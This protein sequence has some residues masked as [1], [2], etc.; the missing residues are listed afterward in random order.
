M[1]RTECVDHLGNKFNSQTE[2]CKYWNVSVTTFIERQKRGCSMQECLVSK[3][4]LS[5][6][7]K[8]DQIYNGQITILGNYINSHSKILVH[9]NVC[10]NEWE[11]LPTVLIRKKHSSCPKCGRLNKHKKCT[12]SHD[13]WI[14]SI[15][16]DKVLILGK[17]TGL[18]NKILVRCTNNNCNHEWYAR[19]YDI[20]TG[21]GC[22][23]CQYVQKSINYTMSKQKFEQR[24]LEEHDASIKCLSEFKG[25][26]HKHTFKCMICGNT[27]DAVANS[28]INASKT[29]CPHCKESNYEKSIRNFLTEKIIAFSTEYILPDCHSSGNGKSRFDFSLPEI[30]FI[31]VDGEG[32]FR[33]VSNWNFAKAV[34]DDDLKTAYCE[35]HGIPL[36]RIRYDQ[37]QDGTYKDLI[38]DF[39]RNPAAYV[40]QHNEFLTAEEYYAER[41]QNLQQSA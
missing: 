25:V 2:M 28:I 31:E 14:A 12:K 27:W 3:K 19:P 15:H 41:N 39:I 16:N 23:K 38:E 35:T 10:G 18:N 20:A 6:F 1:K 34:K 22:P 21:K 37:M 8:V 36:L 11:A 29:G 9:C 7:D 24:L 26:N 13:V 40:L 4:C 32:H 30:G 33:Q 5:F 17:Y